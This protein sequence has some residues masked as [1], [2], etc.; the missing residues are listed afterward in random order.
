M[1][2]GGTVGEGGVKEGGVTEVKGGVAVAVAVAVA[3]GVAV[4]E[5]PAIN[6]EEAAAEGGS[7]EP[8]GV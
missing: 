5:E 7:H 6:S 4:A 3:V 2:G 8:L 1:D